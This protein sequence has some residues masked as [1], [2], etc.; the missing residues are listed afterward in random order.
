M[1]SQQPLSKR[2]K[3]FLIFSDYYRKL[4]LCVL[5]IRFRAN[6]RMKGGAKYIH[7]A[8]RFGFFSLDW[9]CAARLFILLLLFLIQSSFLFLAF[10]HCFIS[11]FPTFTLSHF[12]LRRVLYILFYA[13][14]Y[15]L[16]SQSLNVLGGNEAFRGCSFS[17][18]RGA[19][20]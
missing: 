14:C 17:T 18:K 2:G 4:S 8:S 11:L 19:K 9:M 20:G 1:G 13:A 7:I 6:S 15:G 5:Y 16:S 3:N 12:T 10:L